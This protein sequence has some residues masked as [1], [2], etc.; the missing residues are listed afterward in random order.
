MVDPLLTFGKVTCVTCGERVVTTD[1]AV[2]WEIVM[3]RKKWTVLEVC[4]RCYD[5]S[6]AADG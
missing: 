3:G 1:L 5:E 2:E 4:Q 6:E